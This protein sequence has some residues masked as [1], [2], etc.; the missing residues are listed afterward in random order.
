[1]SLY[2]NSLGVAIAQNTSATDAGGEITL[3]IPRT[4]V[5]PDKLAALCSSLRDSD[6]VK[7]SVKEQSDQELVDH[8]NLASGD[9]LTNLG[10]LLLGLRF[11]RAKL[12]SAPVV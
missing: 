11:D 4:A 1:V 5:D 2:S 6:R 9:L 7:A 3:Q 12:G 10:V 8:Y